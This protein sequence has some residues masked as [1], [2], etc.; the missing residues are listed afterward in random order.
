MIYSNYDFEQGAE[1]NNFNMSILSGIEDIN[2]KEDFQYYLNSSNTFNW[3]ANVIYHTFMPGKVESSFEGFEAPKVDDRYAWDAAAYIAHE[4]K[5]GSRSRLNYGLRYSFFQPVGPGDYFSF[6]DSGEVLD[7]ITYQSGETISQYGGLEPRLSFSFMVDTKSSVKASY[8]RNRQYIHLISNSTSG[9]P[10][11]TW[12]PSSNI[13]EPEIADQISLGY[14]RNFDSDKYETSIE[15]Y[16]KDLQNQIEYKNGADLI[17]NP[18]IESQLVFGEGRSYGIELYAKKR[19]GKLKGWISYS[20]SKTERSFDNIDNGKWFPARHDRT[21]DFSIT[22]IYAIKPELSISASWI[23][24]TGDAVTFPSGKYFIGGQ[25]VNMYTERNGY[26]MPNYHRLDLGLSWI[27]KRTNKWE[28][29]WNFSLYNAY[30]RENAYTINFVQSEEDPSIM[31]AEQTA[32][33]K[34]VPSISWN[35]KF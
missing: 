7:T 4:A 17:A 23:Y 21:H 1:F 24:Y 25:L 6:K 14:Y 10:L 2:L 13:V 22:G 5:I 9:T 27:A 8:N 30:G 11:D 32:L 26:R 18:L 33:F 35:F 34:F 19:S 15:A 31:V 29:S 12:I 16:Y 28:S 3:G 20:L